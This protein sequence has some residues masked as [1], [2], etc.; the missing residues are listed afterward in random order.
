MNKQFHK[1]PKK[2]AMPKRDL[3]CGVVLK[4]LG[5]AIAVIASPFVIYYGTIFLWLSQGTVRPSLSDEL[6]PTA[7]YLLE[8]PYENPV[9]ADDEFYVGMVDFNQDDNELCFV[10]SWFR[11]RINSFTSANKFEEGSVYFRYVEIH[12]NGQLAGRT[13]KGGFLEMYRLMRGIDTECVAG[14]LGNGLHIIEVRTLP[15][16]FAPPNYVQR[17]TIEVDCDPQG[18]LRD[19]SPSYDTFSRARNASGVSPLSEDLAHITVSLTSNYDYYDDVQLEITDISVPTRNAT[20]VCFIFSETP[21]QSDD[22]YPNIGHMSIN[23]G[24][25]HTLF[26][27]HYTNSNRICSDYSVPSGIN[28]ITLQLPNSEI[29]YQWAIE[30]NSHIISI[31]KNQ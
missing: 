19:A 8:N 1:N 4:W 22:E 26:Y 12:I 31:T 11:A 17:W 16:A 7:E 14:T 13:D 10:L 2:K 24:Y 6:I 20:E 27:N 18:C 30:I 15:R 25:E 29:P 23:L 21:V 3:G 28:I 9:R 5:I